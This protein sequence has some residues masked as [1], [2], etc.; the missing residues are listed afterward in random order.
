MSITLSGNF[1]TAIHLI[2]KEIGIINQEKFSI[3]LLVWISA[4][5]YT[6]DRKGDLQEATT[7]E[8][9]YSS[10]FEDHKL[11]YSIEEYS[12]FAFYYR[13]IGNL[14]LS[15]GQINLALKYYEKA[16]YLKKEI[17]E[18]KDLPSI[19]NN[20]GNAY[21]LQGD[22]DKALLNFNQS[23]EGFKDLNNNL[24]VSYPVH[25]IGFVNFL[26]GDIQ[27][28]LKYYKKSLQLRSNA[29]FAS[30]AAGSYFSIIQCYIEL[31]QLD[32][33]NQ[34]YKELIS[35]NDSTENSYVNLVTRLAKA[36]LLK[37]N[38]KMAIKSQSEEIFRQIIEESVIKYDFTVI[39]IVNLV[40]L[41]LFELKI[42]Y[43]DKTFNQIRD[44]ISKI[45]AISKSQNIVPL[46]I[47][48]SILDGK[49]SILE[50]DL[51]KAETVFR[52]GELLASKKGF[53]GLKKQLLN[54]IENLHQKYQDWKDLYYRNAS[55]G[56]R[57]E[58]M[59]LQTY[60]QDLLKQIGK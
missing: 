50:G 34:F 25:N 46:Q 38:P 60:I 20:I 8:N 4:K 2:E 51:T 57:I 58:K 44:L 37:N 36:I 39:A 14:N 32:T 28:A 43:N 24:V 29:K 21:L 45:K 13:S 26:K 9:K 15:L 5:I 55:Y 10:M 16:L 33:A 49:I 56:E 1:S 52:E 18:D 42:E 12:W 31:N 41:L 17:K 54:E 27:Q 35:L 22:L 6:L 47:Q 53:L 7:L 59:E 19:L 11:N 23:F 40:E 30:E 3:M 48:T